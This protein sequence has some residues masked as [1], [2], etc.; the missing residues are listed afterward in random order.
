[1]Y[2]EYTVYIICMHV[3]EYIAGMIP[4][5]PGLYKTYT[6]CVLPL[7][8]KVISPQQDRMLAKIRQVSEGLD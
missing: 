2:V 4:K 1:M 3:Y 6:S 8:R 7:V 5:P